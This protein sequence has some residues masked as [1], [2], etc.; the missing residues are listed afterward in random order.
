M[1]LTGLSKIENPFHRIYSLLSPVH[2]RLLW[3]LGFL[4]I[5]SGLFEI[6][7]VV[8]IMPFMAM[9]VDPER[10]LQNHWVAILHSQFPL[11]DH[12]FMIL[13]GSI[14][15]GI[16]LLSNLLS[17]FTVWSI[18]RFSFLAGCELSKTMFSV[19]LNHPYL[20]FLNRNS[21]ELVQNTLFEIGRLVNSILNPALTLISRLVIAFS[22]IVLLVIINP[23]IAV[24]STIVLGGAYVFIFLL[25]RRT[26]ART[27][28]EVSKEN[29][30]RFQVAY[31][32]FGSIKDIKILGREQAFFNLFSIPV[33]RYSRLQAQSQM[34][35]LLPRYAMETLA[36]GGII[37]I[38]IT[39][40]SMGGGSLSKTLPLISLYALAGYRLM[41]MLQQI[42]SSWS[43]IR[44]NLP[45]VD[46][47]V[48]DIES[49]PDLISD[50]REKTNIRKIP[51]VPG[52]VTGPLPLTREIR[53][54]DVSFVY[55]GRNEPVLDRLTVS[56]PVNASV[57]IVGSTGSGKTTTLDILLGLLDPSSGCLLV[58]G[59]PVTG[60][61]RRRWQRSIGYVPQQIMLIDDSVR[62]NIAFGVTE[63]LID[64]G[65]VIQAARLAHLHDFIQS[66]L[67]Q[68][69][70]TGIGERG[71]RLSG[72]Q[73]QRIGIARALYHDPAVLV[74]DEATSALDNMTEAVIM[75][76]LSTL[77]RQK[78]ILMV[79][80]RLTT[81]REC[82]IIL[83]MDRGRI[84]DIGTYDELLDRSGLFSSMVKGSNDF[85][86]G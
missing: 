10:T 77:S 58:D 65:R 25:V 18:L 29:A 23:L 48:S 54:E 26:L 72:G 24:S 20:F 70:E 15:L 14:V 41:P 7:G 57:G 68:G 52:L 51:D 39:L 60:D 45:A 42:F 17:A 78:T 9:I 86:Q 32:T 31:E 6:A 83:V 40:L 76:A 1:N 21:T 55:P 30:R 22:I 49:L 59:V 43:T 61:N 38:V 11:S 75:E 47:I 12:G 46:I 3:G 64:M 8:S 85:V 27:G 79:A 2:R 71:V 19:Y 33:E 34:I 53:F 66:E 37:V 4:V 16:L 56:I 50:S 28:Q 35:T 13:L 81:V 62:K 82:D 73:R 67:P 84:L 80:H 74:L 36:F 44:F 5:I 69:Y 63:S